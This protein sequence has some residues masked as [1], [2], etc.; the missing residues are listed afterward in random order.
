M[1]GEK[2]TLLVTGGSRGIGAAV[3]RLAARQGYAVCIN[4]RDSAPQAQQVLAE[5]VTAG[6]QGCVIQAD[7]GREEEVQQLFRQLDQ[8]GM[9][10]LTALVNNAGMVAGVRQPFME[11]DPALIRR[12]IDVN[13]LGLFWCTQAAIGRMARSKGGAGGAIVHISSQAGTFGGRHIEAYAASKAAINTFTIGLAREMAREGIRINTVSP[14]VVASGTLADAGD[15]ELA[16]A[17]ATI[18]LGRVAQPEEVAQAVLWLI[19]EQAA[20]ITGIVL[21]VAGGR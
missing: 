9:A 20:Y 5:I 21:P 14:G 10:P 11:M 12:I 4:H 1:N 19:S 3:A 2:G 17:A 16:Q 15:A 8:R 18:P 6:G 7:I 13:L